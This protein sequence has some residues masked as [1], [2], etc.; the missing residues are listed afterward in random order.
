MFSYVGFTPQEIVV[1]NQTTFNIKLLPDAASLEEVVITTFGTAKK[2]SFTGSA[3]KID[4][5]DL[6]PRPITNVG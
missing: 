3:T 2:N 6:A 4:A 1:G 5:K